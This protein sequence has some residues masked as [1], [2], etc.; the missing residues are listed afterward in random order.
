MPS[1]FPSTIYHPRVLLFLIPQCQILR[2]GRRLVSKNI[3]FLPFGPQFGLKIRGGAGPP[4]PFTRSATVPGLSSSFHSS[5]E[6][7]GQ[8]VGTRESLNGRKNVARRKV[9]NGE[10][11]P[12][13]Q[14]LARLVPNGRRSSRRSLLFF[15]RHFS[16]R[17]D[18]PWSPLSAHGSPR[19][20]FIIFQHM[21]IS[22]SFDFS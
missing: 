8:I 18:F 16:A 2:S 19:M 14:C 21:K 7:H 10:K 22:T 11:S 15:A 13:G 6:T 4:G 12:W 1:P 17:L 3:F 9:K 5:S 20:P